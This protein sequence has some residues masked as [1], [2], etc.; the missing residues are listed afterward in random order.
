[1]K[2]IEPP[3]RCDH[4][5]SLR[6]GAFYYCNKPVRFF[7]LS[8]T[9]PQAGPEGGV[10]LAGFC[11]LRHAN[12]EPKPTLAAARQ[13]RDRMLAGCP[14]GNCDTAA[15]A[16]LA[17]ALIASYPYPVAAAAWVLTGQERIEA[18]TGACIAMVAD[19]GAVVFPDLELVCEMLGIDT[20]G[21]E[22]MTLCSDRP[23]VIMWAGASNA[24]LDVIDGMLDTE[25]RIRIRRIGVDAYRDVFLKVG[26][27]PMPVV[28]GEPAECRGSRHWL[29]VEFVWMESDGM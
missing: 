26:D 3:T 19:R 11:G 20:D 22:T 23:D 9:N 10:S 29:P 7:A 28:E 15:L 17:A 24:F 2:L 8:A 13:F 25:K 18:A 4:R 12:V 1:M 5:E 27:A 16:A 21:T 6:P 14:C